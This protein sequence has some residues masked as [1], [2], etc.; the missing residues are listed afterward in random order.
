MC[1]VYLNPIE[2]GLPYSPGRLYKCFGQA[3]DFLPG[4]FFWHYS[5]YGV[6][7]S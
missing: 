1:A 2:S 5:R 3:V 6:C 7:D 4:Q